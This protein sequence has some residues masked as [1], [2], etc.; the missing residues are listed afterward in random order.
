[1]VFVNNEGDRISDWLAGLP[2]LT[3]RRPVC[4]SYELFVFQGSNEFTSNILHHPEL[5]CLTV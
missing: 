2:W 5:E 3:L 1:M 4:I